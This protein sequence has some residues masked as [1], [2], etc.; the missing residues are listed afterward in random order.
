MLVGKSLRSAWVLIGEDSSLQAA[1]NQLQTVH[2]LAVVDSRGNL[3]GVLS[4]S[5]VAKWLAQR[6]DASIGDFANM[7]ID[8]FNFGYCD[9]QTIHQ[10]EKAVRAFV[11]MYK[12]DLS[13]LA[14]VDDNDRVVGNISVSDLKGIQKTR[15]MFR[16]LFVSCLSFINRNEMPKPPVLVS[17][18]RNTSMKEVLERY[19]D[20]NIHRVY[21]VTPG[22]HKVLR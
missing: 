14:V 16:N 3:V 1:I 8:D 11:R 13:G 22:L 15:G 2:R 7:S 19:K 18:T 17:A 9:V 5:R 20:N 12:N 10:D 6:T 21:V 4:Q